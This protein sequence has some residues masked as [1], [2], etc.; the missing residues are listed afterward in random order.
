MLLPFF[1]G[2]P[3]ENSV[4]GF[5]IWALVRRSRFRSVAGNHPKEY[6][7]TSHQRRQTQAQNHLARRLEDR[8]TVRQTRKDQ[9]VSLLPSGGS[10]D[11]V[12]RKRC[13]KGTALELPLGWCQ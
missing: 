11:L 5:R 6:S 8:R 7:R 3:N 12:R 9:P 1:L 13:P 2:V 4:I 10:D